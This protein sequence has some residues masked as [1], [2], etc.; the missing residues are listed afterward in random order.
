MAEAHFDHLSGFDAIEVYESKRLGDSAKFV[1]TR[2]W[3]DA[4]VDLL[5]HAT[6]R[7]PDVA[8]SRHSDGKR[9]AARLTHELGHS[10]ELLVYIP[11]LYRNTRR[12]TTAEIQRSNFLP[13]YPL[14]DF[15]PIMRGELSYL[16]LPDQLV[17]GTS[18]M[19]IEGRPLYEDQG[20]DQLLL[21]FSPESPLAV[22]TTYLRRGRELRRVLIDPAYI[23][24]REGW[25]VPMRRLVIG[26]DG[27]TTELRLRNLLMNPYLPDGFFSEHNLRVQRFPH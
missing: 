1:I 25:L 16:R 14:R 23:V 20:F 2:R 26:R 6:S 9:V 3:S 12:F 21:H 5:M 15:L 7:L 17:D 18:L 22:R 19:V 27:V 11:N 8:A 10:D 4:R 13:L 24:D